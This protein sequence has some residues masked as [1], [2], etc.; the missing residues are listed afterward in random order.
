MEEW[1]DGKIS[2][3]FVTF[4]DVSLPSGPTDAACWKAALKVEKMSNYFSIQKAS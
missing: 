3:D 4:S 2:S 1:I